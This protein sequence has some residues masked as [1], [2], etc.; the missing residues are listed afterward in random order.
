MNKP[1][2]ICKSPTNYN[3]EVFIRPEVQINCFRCGKFTLST[4]IAEDYISRLQ[5][6][7]TEVANI[8]GWVF[9]NQEVIIDNDVYDRLDTLDPPTIADK[10]AKLLK[11]LA[12][13][14]LLPGA[15][16][17]D[18][19]YVRNLSTYLKAINEGS[20]D[21]L[22]PETL[23]EMK[24]ALPLLAASWS[25][26][27][28]DLSYLLEDYLFKTKNYLD[29]AVARDF[30]II[31]PE[32]WAYL[33]SLKYANPESHTAFV[34]MWF[35]KTMDPIYDNVI[36]PA[37]IQAGYEPKRVDRTEHVNRI[38]DEII[39]LIRQSKFVVADYTD[40]RGGVDFESGFAQGM[41]L[42]VIW[43]C[44]KEEMKNLQFDIS[45]YNFIFWEDDKLDDLKES[46][47]N[48]IIHLMGKGPYRP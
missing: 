36:E 17:H 10:A 48:R 34:A 11:Y 35:D 33:D 32:G 24:Q 5:P 45:H 7:S 6:N 9:E 21:T 44:K 47:T 27:E 4:V 13:I 29:T 40:Q 25:Q 12:R 2:P 42:P 22:P 8:S 38:D 3:N 23:K 30:A 15:T 28:I 37:I 26:N 43:T 46:L 20:T 1:C 19:G 16:I 41:G 39:A 14:S 18:I 31:T